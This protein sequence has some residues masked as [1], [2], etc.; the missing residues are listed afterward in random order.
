[1]NIKE[2]FL[3]IELKIRKENDHFHE[4]FCYHKYRI[5]NYTFLFV[6]E[7]NEFTIY[8]N[9]LIRFAIQF[10]YAIKI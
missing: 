5:I 9:F 7:S 3:Y 2:D 8:T 6:F 4:S 10:K 1:M